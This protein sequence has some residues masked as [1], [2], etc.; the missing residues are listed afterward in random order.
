MAQKTCIPRSSGPKR[1]K[2]SSSLLFRSIVPLISHLSSSI[3]LRMV[4]IS[5][6]K[7]ITLVGS[8]FSSPALAQLPLRSLWGSGIS[9]LIDP[10]LY[11]H[12]VPTQSNWDQWGN[13]WIPQLCLDAIRGE[14]L[15]PWDVEVFNVHYTDCSQAWTFCRV[16]SPSPLPMNSLYE[17]YRRWNRVQADVFASLASWCQLEVINARVI[18]S[19]V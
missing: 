10:S 16:S 13:G 8:L 4:Y 5:S 14:N 9:G 19:Q 2:K 11:Q 7:S 1:Y 15:S 17:T 18:N 3:S 12:L 6:L